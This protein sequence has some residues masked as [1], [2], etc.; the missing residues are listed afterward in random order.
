MAHTFNDIPV[1]TQQIKNCSYSQWSPL[2]PKNVIKAKVFKPLPK[3]FITYLESDSIK[4]PSDVL[5][6]QVVRTSDNEYSDWE[7]EESSGDENSELTTNK[8]GKKISKN[9]ISGFEDLHKDIK[10][11]ISDLGGK[12]T[13]KLNWSS[14]KDAKWILP[15]STTK[16]FNANDVY[17]LLN[18]SDHIVHDLDHSFDE[19]VD[20]DAT[21]KVEYELVLKQWVDINP[22][23]EF[24]VFIKGGKIIG[25][26]QRDLNHYDYLA[27]LKDTFMDVISKFVDEEKIIQ[28]FPDEDFIIDLYIPRPF[29]KC[30]IIDINPFSRK[31]DSLLY[32]WHELSESDTLDLEL[33]LIS[34][35]NVGRFAAKEH[36]ENYVP[37]DVLDASM[38]SS[39]MADLA[40]EWAKLGTNSVE[41]DDEE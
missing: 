2:F 33:R 27:D 14:P 23:L 4:L 17:L 30:W 1:T 35:T 16:S 10:R 28:K 26:S 9:P 31:T 38:D 24:R 34:E 39:A 12:V 18:A 20:F 7:D 19:C 40:R 6:E 3:S 29:S 11:A 41:S 5:E 25:I 15:N 32:T 21:D 13:P 36:S 37:R 8:N 22:A